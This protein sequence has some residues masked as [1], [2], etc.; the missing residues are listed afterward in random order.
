MV[1]V[2]GAGPQLKVIT[3][4]AATAATTAADVQPAGVPL[5]TTRSG[6]LVS[7]ACAAAGTVASP[8]GLP[9][10]GRAC[11]RFDADGLGVGDE[12]GVGGAETDAD[13]EADGEADT[14]AGDDGDT[15]AGA[16]ATGV[17]A[18]DAGGWAVPSSP[19]PDRARAQITVAVRA[20]KEEDRT[21][22]C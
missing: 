11:G 15:E 14:G 13:T 16:E 20:G 21:A 1:I 3:P 2:T 7:T 22:Q 8:P 12:R 17:G 4:P 5:P 10:L 18:S 19:Q 9:G 6:R